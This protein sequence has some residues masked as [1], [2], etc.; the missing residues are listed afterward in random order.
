G[1][2]RP[3]PARGRARSTRDR[4]HLRQSWQHLDPQIEREP[5]ILAAQLALD[6][7]ATLPIPDPP[8]V[9]AEQTEQLLEHTKARDAHMVLGRTLVERRQASTREPTPQLPEGRDLWPRE[10]IRGRGRHPRIGKR[11]SHRPSPGFAGGTMTGGC[12]EPFGFP[13]TL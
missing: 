9:L 12:A 4:C 6:Q 2:T 8:P 1:A 11:R 5:P 13:K 10:R 7:A 3:S